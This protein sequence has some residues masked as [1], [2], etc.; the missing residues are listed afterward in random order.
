MN[1]GFASVLGMMA[2]GWLAVRLYLDWFFLTR[3]RQQALG[4]VVRH[5]LISSDEGGQ[6]PVL[7]VRFETDDGQIADVRDSLGRWSHQLDVGSI[8]GVEYPD[9]HPK[10]ARLL[11]SRRVVTDYVVC[12]AVLVVCVTYMINPKWI[13]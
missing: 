3:P 6:T 4:T 7:V 12:I 2:L 1:A 11:Q 8:I 13:T 10:K 9:G 5:D